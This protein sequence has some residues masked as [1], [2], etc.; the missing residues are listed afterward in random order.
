MYYKQG[1]IVLIPYPFTDLSQIKQRPAVIISRTTE[2]QSSYIVAKVTSVIRSD[3]F[4]FRLLT[5]EI[6]R[7]LKYDSEVRINE[8]FTVSRNI[9]IK[10]FATISRP[11][12]LELTTK[13]KANI[14]VN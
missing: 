6:D 10:R 14:S 1:D 8:I 3:Q 7:E 2:N 11:S 4:S 5:S 12:M 9:I 13:I